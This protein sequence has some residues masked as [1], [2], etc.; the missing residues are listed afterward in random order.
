MKNQMIG[1]VSAVICLGTS[2]VI[3]TSLIVGLMTYAIVVTAVSPVVF[4]V[5][6]LMTEEG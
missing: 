5:C 3:I 2:A 4:L 1:I 6:L